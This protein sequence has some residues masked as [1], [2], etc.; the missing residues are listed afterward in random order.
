MTTQRFGGGKQVTGTPSLA[1]SCVVV[2]ASLLAGASV[3]HNVFKPNM[4]L[5][6]VETGSGSK[7]DH[8]EKAEP[9]LLIIISGFS[10]CLKRLFGVSASAPALVLFNIFTLA[11]DPGWF[12]HDCYGLEGAVG[13]TVSDAGRP[14]EVPEVTMELSS[15]G[16]TLSGNLV[17]STMMFAA[18]QVI[19]QSAASGHIPG[20][21]TEGMD[22]LSHR[23]FT[24]HAGAAAENILAQM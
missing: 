5:P 21:N 8:P 13:G 18:L 19:W 2:V 15:S 12:T 23:R 4:R 14:C 3:V 17:V 16:T 20:F 22:A 7:P 10:K 1:W 9:L 24:R 6:P 11:S